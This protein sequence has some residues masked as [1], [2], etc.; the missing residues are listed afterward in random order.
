MDTHAQHNASAETV[1]QA[2]LFFGGNCAEAVEFYKKALGAEIDMMMKF[3]ESPDPLPPGLGYPGIEDKVMHASF[4]IG[5]TQVMVSDGCDANVGAPKF[6]GFSLSI[7]VHK[8]ADADRYFNA[9]AKDGQVQMPLGKTFFSPRFGAVKDK[10]G[11]S[12]MVVMVPAGQ[13]H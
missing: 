1:V 13:A 5:A 9:L 4:R 2:Y 11:V 12:W 7:A 8:E 6:D 3:K 10:F